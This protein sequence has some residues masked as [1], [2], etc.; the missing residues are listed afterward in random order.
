M[1]CATKEDDLFGGLEVLSHFLDVWWPK[2][3]RKIGF[4]MGVGDFWCFWMED[5]NLG[6]KMEGTYIR[7]HFRAKTCHL[8]EVRATCEVTWWQVAWEVA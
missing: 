6:I 2:N 7:Y 3:G 1:V 4:W 5:R 8:A